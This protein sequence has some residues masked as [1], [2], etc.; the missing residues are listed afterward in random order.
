MNT[1]KKQMRLFRKEKKIIMETTVDESYEHP[2]L[3]LRPMAI[4]STMEKNI[5]ARCFR[6]TFD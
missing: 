5:I 2:N 1:V 4:V 6:C 3:M